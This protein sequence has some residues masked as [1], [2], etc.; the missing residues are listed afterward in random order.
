MTAGRPIAVTVSD[1]D[2]ERL[3]K[4][5]LIVRYKVTGMP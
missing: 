2:V 3:E 5:V 1:V 4:T